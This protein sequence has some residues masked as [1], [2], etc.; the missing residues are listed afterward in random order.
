[1]KF[2]DSL[3]G[4][5]PFTH[6]NDHFAF[7]NS[8]N[9][10]EGEHFLLLPTGGNQVNLV[11]S[12][13][14]ATVETGGKAL[15]FGILGSRR[16]SFFKQVSVG[17]AVLRQASLRVTRSE[18]EKEIQAP[19]MKDF[20]KCESADKFSRDSTAEPGG[21]GFSAKVLENPRRPAL[22]TDPFS[23]SLEKKE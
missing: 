2:E 11:H 6:V 21:K 22:S 20:A 23:R 13:F 8:V 10:L 7:L 18:E 14:E 4:D 12:C 15:V 16:S 19:L 9:F 1:M 5:D 17:Q 3:L